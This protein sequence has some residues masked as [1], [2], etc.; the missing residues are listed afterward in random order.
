MY[1][2]S[3]LALA[4]TTFAAAIPQTSGDNGAQGTFEVTDF[5]FGCTAGCNWQFNVTNPANYPLH[6]PVAVSVHCEGAWTLSTDAIDYVA[7]DSISDTQT[8]RAYIDPVT[9][10]LSLKYEVFHP[11]DRTTS[12]FTGN[13]TVFAA[14]SLNA[15][16]QKP[17]FVV[18]EQTATL[19]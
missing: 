18:N 12:T 6:P 9:S 3:L 13:A 19:V 2:A 15:D 8:I 11:Y 17:E 10:E 1:A 7:C 4:A 16:L 14:T 5:S